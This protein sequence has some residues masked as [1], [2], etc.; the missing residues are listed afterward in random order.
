MCQ[1]TNFLDYKAATLEICEELKVRNGFL[2][3][4]VYFLTHNKRQE[5]PFFYYFFIIFVVC[6]TSIDRSAFV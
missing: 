2:T 1:E 4:N 5:R 3:F 6:I